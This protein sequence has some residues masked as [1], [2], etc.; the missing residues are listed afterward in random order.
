M[1]HSQHYPKESVTAKRKRLR[2]LK[3]ISADNE[4]KLIIS[5]SDVEVLVKPHSLHSLVSMLL[6]TY[7]GDYR[8]V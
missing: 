8:T 4:A 5:K 2:K 7:S 1:R 6:D 3:D